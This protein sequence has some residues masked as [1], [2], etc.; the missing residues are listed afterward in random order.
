MRRPQLLANMSKHDQEV[1]ATYVFTQEGQHYTDWEFN[2]LTGMPD[3]PGVFYPRT[4][5]AQ[6]LYLNALKIDAIAWFLSSPTVIECKPRA[7]L[8][9][10]G[11]AVAYRQWYQAHYGVTPN[12]LIVCSSM[13]A[14]VQQNAR[15]SGIDVRLVQPAQ[16]QTIKA[17]IDY[18]RPRVTRK[19]IL[20]GLQNIPGFI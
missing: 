2:V 13:S 1:F 5:R 20:P 10:I 9:A 6:A 3:D 19:S 8:S 4:Q 16:P 17:A 14:Q 7:G 12:A 15:W 11:Q 18:L